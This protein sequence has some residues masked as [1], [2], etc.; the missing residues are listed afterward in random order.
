MK[1]AP[2]RQW[3]DFL[4][5]ESEWQITAYFW[6]FWDGNTSTQANPTHAYQKA[7]TYTVTLKLDFANNNVLDK[8][9]EIE[10]IE[11]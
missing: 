11:E 9:V 3:I 7:G 1:K 4:S 10:I 2:V 8:T 6:D 5:D